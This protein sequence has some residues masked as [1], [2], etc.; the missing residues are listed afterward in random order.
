MKSLLKLMNLSE[1]EIKI[2]VCLYPDKRMTS[3][4]L[5]KKLNI[6]Q[7]SMSFYL[8]SLHKRRFIIKSRSKSK[9]GRPQL[10]IYISQRLK[11]RMIARAG[12][13]MTELDSMDLVA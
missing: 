4:E 5:E 13:L 2:I 12:H 1:K 10:T 7:P 3:V 11:D 6:R 8:K 9:H